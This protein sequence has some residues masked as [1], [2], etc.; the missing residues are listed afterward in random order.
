MTTRDAVLDEVDK[1]LWMHFPDSPQTNAPYWRQT[2]YRLDFCRL[3]IRA[4]GIVNSDALKRRI[5][6]HWNIQ[7]QHPLPRDH[8]RDIEEL[9]TDWDAWQFAYKHL[10]LAEGE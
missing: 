8:E 5:E 2:E 1:Y 9:E 7:R 3:S 6:S 4:V 10:R